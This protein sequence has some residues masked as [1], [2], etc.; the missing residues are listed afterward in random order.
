M[1]FILDALATQGASPAH[2]T[3]RRTTRARAL[4]RLA[5]TGMALALIGSLGWV[6]LY[7]TRAKRATVAATA[8]SAPSQEP[9]H[10]AAVGVPTMAPRPVRHASEAPA[11]PASA[12]SANRSK[13]MSRDVPRFSPPITLS[14]PLPVPSPLGPGGTFVAARTVPAPAA[15]EASA[16]TPRAVSIADLKP[17]GVLAPDIRAML[18]QMK[19]QVLFYAPQ[20]R[21]RFVMIDGRE[22]REGDELFAGLRL[23]EITDTGMVLRHKE[24]LVLSPAPEGR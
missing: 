15:Q 10:M 23:Q 21:S 14:Q 8:A 13:A 9:V 22:L 1:S 6:G 20:P 16:E 5:V 19:L 24:V 2:G 11:S 3:K 7:T 4:R 17:L 18:A 12:T